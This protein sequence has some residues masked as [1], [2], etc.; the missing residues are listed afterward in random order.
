MLGLITVKNLRF[1]ERQPAIGNI[2]FFRGI[3]L[4]GKYTQV[5]LV[6]ILNFI[7]SFQSFYEFLI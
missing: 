2:L 6:V 3:K 7:D 5:F 1:I 4:F